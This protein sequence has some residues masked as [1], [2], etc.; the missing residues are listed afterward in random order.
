V[1][2]GMKRQAEYRQRLREAGFKAIEV[3]VHLDDIPI[4][5]RLVERL[6]KRRVKT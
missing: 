6:R 4:V 2:A 5:K 1:K 3:W